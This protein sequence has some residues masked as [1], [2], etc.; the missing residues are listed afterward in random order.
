[1][2][3]AVLELRDIVR[4]FRQGEDRLEVLRGASLHVAAGEIVALTGPSGAGKS[5]FLHIAGLLERADAGEVVVRGEA[6]GSLSDDERTTLRRRSIGFVYQFH[7]LLPEFTALEN[8]VLPQ[9]IAGVG[10]AA[11]GRRA[12]EMLEMTGIA[13]RARHRPAEMSGGQ[14][15]RVAIARAFANQPEIL[16]ADEPTGN[17][18]QE[19]ADRMFGLLLDLVR[20][21]GVGALVATHNPE[22]AARMDRELTVRNGALEE[23]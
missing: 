15:Q 23:A 18:D 3:D 13:E 6:C 11:A 22:L 17:L 16:I 14:Q 21:Q 7:H 2:S 8:L 4:T 12:Q 1:M 20:G 9:M 5:T 10:R 19:T